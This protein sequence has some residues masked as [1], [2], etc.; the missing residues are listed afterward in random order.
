MYNKSYS[1]QAHKGKIIPLSH[2]TTKVTI[3]T[4]K[5]P[6]HSSNSKEKSL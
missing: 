3:A 6:F 5:F 4:H 1:N 2:L